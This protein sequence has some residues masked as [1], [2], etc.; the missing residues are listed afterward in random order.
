[1]TRA[2]KNTKERVKGLNVSALCHSDVV[3]MRP[4]FGVWSRESLQLSPEESKAHSDGFGEY[5]IIPST[6]CHQS[7]HRAATVANHVALALR[8]Q[9]PP[10][11]ICAEYGGRPTGMEFWEQWQ[12][13]FE[14][15]H[16]SFW[17]VL[18]QLFFILLWCPV[19]TLGITGGLML[20][21][22]EASDIDSDF[23]CRV[24]RLHKK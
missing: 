14:F 12:C 6:S 20:V 8:E 21:S 3:S 5:Y 24:P 13:W 7:K 1:M 19:S 18:L 11:L 2:T 9:L 22:P 15:G 10:L 16:T 23:L 4:A 17:L